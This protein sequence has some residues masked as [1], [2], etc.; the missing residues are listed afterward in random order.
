MHAGY[1]GGDAVVT[2]EVKNME[3]RKYHVLKLRPEDDGVL[4]K[5]ARYYGV[6]KVDVVRV[7]IYEKARELGL[8]GEPVRQDEPEPE[9]DEDWYRVEK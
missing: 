5:L 8:I 2:E 7:L 9:P 3:N 6:N 1:L 4:N